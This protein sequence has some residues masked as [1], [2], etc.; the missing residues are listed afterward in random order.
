[1]ALPGGNSG[2]EQVTVELSV[3]EAMA[4]STGVRFNAEPSLAAEAKRKVR[5]KVE[6][7]LLSGATQAKSSQ[8][9]AH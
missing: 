3:K 2:T 5:S 7:H 1:M 8:T 4:L 6:Q 9:H